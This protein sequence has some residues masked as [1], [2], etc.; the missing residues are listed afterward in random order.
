M[1]VFVV[2][3]MVVGIGNLIQINSAEFIDTYDEMVVDSDRNE[4]RYS[5]KNHYR[6]MKSSIEEENTLLQTHFGIDSQLVNEQISCGK[7]TNNVA[8]G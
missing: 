2:G 1:Y 8:L 4:I 6:P 5:L 3:L 7:I